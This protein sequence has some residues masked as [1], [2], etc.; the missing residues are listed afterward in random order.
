MGVV[1]G[2]YIMES[3]REIRRLE[4]KTGF[5]AKLQLMR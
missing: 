3:P 5:E 2:E 1:R 4:L